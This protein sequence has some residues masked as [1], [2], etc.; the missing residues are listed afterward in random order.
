MQLRH[1]FSK[2]LS[3]LTKEFKTLNRVEISRAAILHNL[4]LLQRLSPGPNL[5]VVL[6]SN[7]YGHGLVEI[8]EILKARNFSYIAVDGY[9]EALRIREVSDQPI[10]VMGYIHLDNFQ[11]MHCEKFTF[12][13]H[14]D[15]TVEALG[16]TG[17]PIKVH[18]E[19]ET[20][21]NRMGVK[22]DRLSDL[23]NKIRLY[24]NLVVEG[25]MT[26][27]ADADN[28]NNSL[29]I[30]QTKAFDMGVEQIQASG[31]K[32]SLFHIAQSAGSVKV[33]SK[34]ANALRAG[35]ALYGINSLA[36]NDPKS[37]LLK[38]LR[39]AMS[40]ISTI[41]KVLEIESGESVSYG[42]TFTAQRPTRIGVIPFGY[43]EGLPRALSNKGIVT[44]R[45]Q[46]LPIVGRVCMNHTLVDITD[47]IAQYGDEVVVVSAKTDEPNSISSINKKHGLFNYEFMVGMNEN[48]R[49]VIIV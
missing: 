32:P 11:R 46:A 19:L 47:S 1:I 3:Q 35:I 22:L 20:G 38:S 18:I 9:Y 13:V 43:Y 33:V 39:P 23:L 10:L 24:K 2:H 6:K 27:L 30:L 12:V 48:T 44:Y 21:M 42:C 26:H 29:T 31:F 41:I 40:V 5:I 4:D 34:Y 25:A 17:K 49:R 37:E 45:N 28:Q 36:D 8:A 15:Q 7:A 14:D 16:K